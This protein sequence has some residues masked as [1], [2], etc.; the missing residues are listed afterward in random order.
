MRVPDI[1]YNSGMSVRRIIH[2]FLIAFGIVV[3]ASFC[4]GAYLMHSR[5][6]PPE[7]SAS[8]TPATNSID[9]LLHNAMLQLNSKHVEQALIA[10]RKALTFAPNSVDVQ[11]GIAQAELMAGR[12]SVA[13]LEYERVLKLDHD[14]AA[15]LRQLGRIYSHERESWSRS[16]AKY[17]E[18]LRLKPDDA[19][20]QLEFARVIA[21][22]R[23]PKE[24]VEIF[25]RDRV[26]PLLNIQDQK[27][28]AFALV[29]TG[30]SSEAEPLLKKLSTTL[31]RDSEVR[32]QLASIYAARRDWPKALP[33]YEALLRENPSDARLN[34]TYGAGLLA[35]KNYKSALRP[36]ERARTSM[37]SSS[38]AG[39]AYARALKGS[40]NLKKAAKEFGRVVAT[41]NDVGLTREYADLLLEKRDYR[42]AEKSYKQAMRSGLRDSRLLLG[43]AGALRGNGKTREAIPYLEEAYAKEPRDGVAFE[44]ASALRKAGHHKE[45]LSVLSK[46]ER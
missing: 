36:L 43:L 23:K 4:Y 17:R 38:A 26:R 37:P 10:Y 27:D 40:G 13:A 3:I 34:L 15:A 31:P 6:A 45:A 2:R 1:F 5:V 28:Y 44:L 24:A 20:A 32:L 19:E 11:F 25:S 16:E 35:L 21:W 30:R 12:E 46:I 39:L 9:E 42:G 22:E 8:S 14:N 41:T 7:N 18:F 33:L 29:Q